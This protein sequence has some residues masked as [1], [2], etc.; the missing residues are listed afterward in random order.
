MALSMPWLE[1]ISGVFAPDGEHVVAAALRA[2]LAPQDK[3]RHR[4]LVVA[5]GTVV[6]EI[7]RGAGAV[8]GASPADRLRIF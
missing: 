3:E 2:A 5:V 4:E 6:F 7:D 8:L 1:T